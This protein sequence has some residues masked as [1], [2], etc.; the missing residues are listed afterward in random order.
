MMDT[1]AM[2]QAMRQA[3]RHASMRDAAQKGHA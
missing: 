3:M 1:D 2:R